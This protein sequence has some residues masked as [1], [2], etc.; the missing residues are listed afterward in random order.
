MANIFCMTGAAA[1]C[2]LQ[3]FLMPEKPAIGSRNMPVV[4]KCEC[5]C[6]SKT[7][8]LAGMLSQCLGS[9]ST[10]DANRLMQPIVRAATK[11]V[12]QGA[13]PAEGSPPGPEADKVGL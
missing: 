3:S 1:A 7:V 12:Q 11:A 2:T 4:D 9:R 8:P 5:H 6:R 13:Q 10:D